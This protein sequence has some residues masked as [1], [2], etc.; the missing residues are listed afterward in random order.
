ML[1]DP[2]PLSPSSHFTR[3]LFSSSAQPHR[4]DLFTVFISAVKFL[5]QWHRRGGVM[6]RI[7]SPCLQPELGLIHPSVDVKDSRLGD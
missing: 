7:Q 1:S 2:R 6:G 5:L 4:A 3:A